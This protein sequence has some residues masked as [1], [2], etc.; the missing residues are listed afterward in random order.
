MGILSW[1]KTIADILAKE[2]LPDLSGS[3]LIVASDSSLKDG[4][5]IHSALCTN[6]RSLLRWDPK[7]ISI[8]DHFRLDEHGLHY[9]KLSP[10]RRDWGAL[11]PTLNIA[12]DL[13]GILLVVRYPEDYSGSAK[14]IDR[15]SQAGMSKTKHG[16]K[17]QKYVDMVEQVCL[18]NVLFGILAK[19][20]QDVHWLTDHEPHFNNNDQLKDVQNAMAH[21]TDLF[22]KVNLG[23]RGIT[24]PLYPEKNEQI[25][26]IVAIPDLCAGAFRDLFAEIEFGN[27]R[28]TV[29]K[30]S[31]QNI[32]MESRMVTITNWFLNENSGKLIKRA[33]DL[34]STPDQKLSATV[35]V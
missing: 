24:T 13:Q 19:E 21:A 8:R 15:L 5:I 33:I 29:W 23:L 18:A 26:D 27:E 2:N 34:T 14:T 4:Y 32:K 12:S 31:G 35:L 16:W 28:S 11:N 6:E 25:R 30:A 3:R 9:K 20:E 22:V 1:H 7:R 10:K 17:A